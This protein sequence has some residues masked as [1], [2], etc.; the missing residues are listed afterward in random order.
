LKFGLDVEASPAELHL[1]TVLVP[2]SVSDCSFRFLL[3]ETALPE[4]DMDDDDD[5]DD[6]N[7]LPPDVVAVAV[8]LR[9]DRWGGTRISTKHRLSQNLTRNTCSRTRSLKGLPLYI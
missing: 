6:D 4:A 7:L 1:C 5:E 8:L 9:A 2:E 3:D